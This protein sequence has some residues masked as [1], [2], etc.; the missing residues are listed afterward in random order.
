MLHSGSHEHS[1][2]SCI[3]LSDNQFPQ[4][5]GVVAW[6]SWCLQWLV[7]LSSPMPSYLS[8]NWCL[9]YWFGGFFW[10]GLVLLEHLSWWI[11]DFHINYK[12]A[13]CVT[14][15]VACW[16]HTWG[17]WPFLYIVIMQ[18]LLPCWI[19]AQT[20]A[21]Q[22][23]ISRG[24]SFGSLLHII[25]VLK[26]SMLQ[27][28]LM[29]WLTIFHVCMNLSICRGFFSCLL[30]SGFNAAI[31]SVVSHMSVATYF[32]LLGTYFLPLI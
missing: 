5:S 17:N 12:E 6:I 2:R 26:L 29:F 32:W 9:Y 25:F 16:C 3:A 31:I 10:R 23:C 20:K 28:S 8:S 1:P 19:K 18:L 24:G 14:L 11:F 15:S 22:W 21:P 13:I 27:A 30:G 7:W 4:G